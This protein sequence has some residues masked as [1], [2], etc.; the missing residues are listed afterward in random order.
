MRRMTSARRQGRLSD[1]GYLS[2]LSF[3]P[4]EKAVPTRSPIV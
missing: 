3:L 1:K 2:Y 4:S